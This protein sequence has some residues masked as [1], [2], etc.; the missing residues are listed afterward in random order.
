MDTL[1]T[2]QPRILI[3]GGTGFAGSHLVELL[4]ER[5]YTDVHVTTF[6]AKEDYVARLLDSSHI[7]RVDLTDHAA[8]H[9]LFVRLAPTQIY[10]LAAFADVGASFEKAALVMQNNTSLQ[11]NV[12]EAIKTAVPKARVLA[13]GSALEYGL[14]TPEETPV[15]ESQA[16]RPVNPYAVSKVTQELLA[17]MYF[18]SHHLDIVFARSFNHVGERQTTAFAVPAFAAQIVEIE[19]GSQTSIK[20]GNLDAQR[21]FTDVKDVARAYLTLMEH[22]ESGTV[23]NVGSGQPVSMESVLSQLVR[24]ANVKVAVETD[25]ARVRP[26]DIPVMVADI[27][28]IKLLGWQPQI[29]LDKTLQR[30]LEWYRSN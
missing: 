28:K 22:G 14:V 15:V 1:L 5:G 3:T 30:V 16:F 23:Y 8:T 12:L 7:H 6:S 9:E 29:P 17:Y 4:L 24:M 13:V 2:E 18:S 10:H 25:P 11:L 19:R 27:S 26:V 20:V 21:D